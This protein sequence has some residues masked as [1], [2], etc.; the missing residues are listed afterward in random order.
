MS[1]TA[2]TE[3]R[4]ALADT[5]LADS[6]MAGL[7]S[8]PGVYAG[9]AKPTASLNYVVIGP[10]LRDADESYLN[11]HDGR[12]HQRRLSFWART[13]TTAEAMYAR[14]VT[15]L[16]RARLDVD[17]HTVIT[18]S[19]ALEAGPVKAKTRPDDPTRGEVCWGIHARWTVRTLEA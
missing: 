7:T 1:Q 11:G 19:L 18:A 3:L 13:Q 17:G 4:D 12:G 5:L 8:P 9:E 14:A 15:L 10:V 6:A 16:D 2:L